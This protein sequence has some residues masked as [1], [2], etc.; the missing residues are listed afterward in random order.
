ML[1]E[2]MRGIRVWA[3]VVGLIVVGLISAVLKLLAGFAVFAIT[4]QPL[5]GL[6][7]WLLS[8]LVVTVS[9]GV[10]GFVA[11]RMSKDNPLGAALLVGLLETSV[12]A[13]FI[14]GS[15]GLVWTWWMSTV[16]LV[17]LMLGA[18]G[19]GYFAR[20]ATV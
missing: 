11:A 2:F 7:W 20:H 1:G 12:A 8:L 19:G 4:R 6:R 13:W 9:T 15:G 17:L 5:V 10:G 16:Y 18:A 3:V 14:F